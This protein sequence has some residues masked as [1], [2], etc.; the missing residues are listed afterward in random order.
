M[1]L[2][3]SPLVI[4]WSDDKK[5]FTLQIDDNPLLEFL[6]LPEDLK[7]SGLLCSNLLCGVIRGALEM[8]HVLVEAR[9]IKCTLKGDE[10]T[11]LRVK[12]IRIVDERLPSNYGS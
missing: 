4:N 10:T 9:C 7:E 6:E 11:Q 1:F 12:L 5:E 2:G 8:V 3:I